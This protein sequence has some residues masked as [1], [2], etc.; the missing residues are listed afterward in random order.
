MV[1]WGLLN[2]FF[3]PPA[4]VL[5]N[6]MSLASF[7]VLTNAG[8]LEAKGKHMRYSKLFNAGKIDEGR[9]LRVGSRIGMLVLYTPALLAGFSSFFL[10][11][12]ANWRFALLRLAITA[13]FFKRDVEVLL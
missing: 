12:E 3:P 6:A 5:V 11:P 10:F 7:A 4:S 13:H 2:V 9:K 1:A 8:W